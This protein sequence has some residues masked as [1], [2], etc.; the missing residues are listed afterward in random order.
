MH[1]CLLLD[2][3]LREIAECLCDDWDPEK[4]VYLDGS[5]RAAARLSRCCKVMEE[6]VLEVLWGRSQRSFSTLLRL[7]PSHLLYVDKANKLVSRPLQARCHQFIGPTVLQQRSSSRRLV[8]IQSVRQ[9]YA[10][11]CIVFFVAQ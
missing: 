10:E 4:G 11:N 7:L 6:P 5:L 1:R 8:A 9:T 3:I 2:E